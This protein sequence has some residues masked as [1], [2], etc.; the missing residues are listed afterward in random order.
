M[1]PDTGGSAGEGG[2]PLPA[3]FEGPPYCHFMF[4][5]NNNKHHNYNNMI[6]NKSLITIIPIT[7]LILGTNMIHND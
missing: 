7:L 3:S 2:R 5:I 6:I 1:I 4:E